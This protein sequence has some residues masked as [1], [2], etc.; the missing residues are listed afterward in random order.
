MSTLLCVSNCC[1]SSLAS[2][3]TYYHGIVLPLRLIC[4]LWSS[5]WLMWFKIDM[6]R[7]LNVC[8]T[9]ANRLLHAFLHLTIADLCPLG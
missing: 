7:P 3:L 5:L 6:C 2:P 4:L 8:P 9:A 1:K